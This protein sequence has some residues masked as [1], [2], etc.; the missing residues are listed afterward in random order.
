MLGLLVS[1]LASAQL[2]Y[3]LQLSLDNPVSGSTVDN[4]SPISVDFTLSNNG[5]DDIPAGDTLW[6][7][8]SDAS[9]SNLYSLSNVSGQA[10]GFILA[11]DLTS[12]GSVSSTNFGGPFSFDLTSWSAGDTAIVVCLGA[13]AD[14]LS[15]TGDVS[16]LAFQNN[17]DLFILGQTSGIVEL[18]NDVT[19]F[20]VPTKNVLNVNATAEVKSIQV[21]TM[22]GKL[23]AEATNSNQV[24]VSKLPSGV[25]LYLIETEVGIARNTFVKE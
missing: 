24:D 21:L 22:D 25:Y 13:G 18:S 7:V 19:V 3:D 5:P 12:G 4:S 15:Q 16:E 20:P 6:F 14:A 11:N 9:F 10:S 2:S 23:V 17:L 1:T 8:Y